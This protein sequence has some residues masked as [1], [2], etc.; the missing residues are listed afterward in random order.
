MMYYHSLSVSVILIV[1]CIDLLIYVFLQTFLTLSL[2][3][4]ANR[5]HLQSSQEA[6]K[7]LHNMVCSEIITF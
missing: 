4:V 3:D 6:E 2:A 7:Y 5:V 1:L